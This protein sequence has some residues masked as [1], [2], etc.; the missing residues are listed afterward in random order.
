MRIQGLTR[1]PAAAL[2]PL[3]GRRCSWRSLSTTAA[4]IPL[5]S[6][7]GAK[8]WARPPP[9][10]HA[11]RFEG[12]NC[13]VT[14]SRMG[15]GFTI[16]RSL[17]AEG[18]NVCLVDLKDASEA[19]ATIEQESGSGSI[20]HL[21]CDITDEAAV[22]AMGARVGELFGGEVHVLVNNAGYNGKCQ[23]VRDMDLADWELTL[24]INLTGTMLVTRELI[25]HLEAARGNVCNLA[26][27]VGR[28]GLPY[29]GDYVCS[30]WAVIG[31]TQTLALELVDA[32][33]RVNA[34]CPGPIEGE[35]I[36]QVMDMH[37]QAEGIVSPINIPLLP[38]SHHDSA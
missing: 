37:M 1:R 21:Q 14:G 32:G 13:V 27:N 28:R 33:V 5:T 29:R 36:E 22:V 31:L 6:N 3:R 17:A 10:A 34:V 19:A 7:D 26:S 18:A 30:K 35:R 4:K 16:A 9:P 24:R 23:L 12:Q 25:P 2:P 8:D 20:H 11:A 38:S 15:L